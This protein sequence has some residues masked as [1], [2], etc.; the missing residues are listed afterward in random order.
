[1]NR[2]RILIF[3][4][5]SALVGFGLLHCGDDDTGSTPKPDAAIDTGAPAND[6]GLNIGD[7]AAD[8]KAVVSE[9][10]WKPQVFAINLRPQPNATLFGGAP[11]NDPG[12]TV[13]LVAV[14]NEKGMPARAPDVYVDSKFVGGAG[15]GCIAYK[16]SPANPLD[17]KGPG[18]THGDM[19]EVTLTGYTGGKYVAGP[20]F[21]FENDAGKD[22]PKP[23]V[24]KRG[25]LIPDSGLFGYGCGADG[26]PSTDFPAT[27]FLAKTDML[28][29]TA[30]GGAD[31]KGWALQVP[32]S[33]NDNIAI[34]NDLWNVTGAM[35]DGSQDLK[36]EYDCGGAP[37]GMAAFVN[38]QIQTSDGRALADAP[39]NPFDFPQAKGEFGFVNCVDF[40]GFNGSGF[41]VAKEL[42]AAI[43]NT[44]TDARVVV[45]TINAATDQ[46]EGQPTLLGAGYARFGITHRTQ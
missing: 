19:G 33:P 29:V 41:T 44:W 39:P 28:S 36:I 27:G 4:L 21:V 8:N 25:E 24:C 16:F 9:R 5:L 15:F 43:P 1:M 40:L 10:K 26:F 2:G 30:A 6:S 20:P 32:P 18:L 35:I 42:L 34:K 37:C 12:F 13:P 38:V 17:P 7:V 3:N 23:I 45:S 46:V 11:G 31:L 14:N 22:I